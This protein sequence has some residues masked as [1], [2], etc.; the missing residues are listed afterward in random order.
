MIVDTPGMGG[1]GAG[2]AA[3]TMSFLPFADGLLFASDASAELS[4]P[5]VEFLRRA[6]EL[7]PTV[8]FVQTKIDLYPSWERIFEL[9]RGHLARLG[10]DVPMV[11]VSSHL[12]HAAL[13]RIPPRNVVGSEQAARGLP[14]P[15]HR[16]QGQYEDAR[17]V[18]PDREI[19][20]AHV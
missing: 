19:G 15:R 7:C 4:A 3:A 20:R 11:A 16:G 9:N 2:H 6:T 13:A 14:L 12:R 1:L 18:R 10:V 8:L 17:R 5:E